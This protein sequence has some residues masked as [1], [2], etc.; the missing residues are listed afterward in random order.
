MSYYVF[1]DD[2]IFNPTEKRFKITDDNQKIL[3]HE[4]TEQDEGTYKCS[5]N[6]RKGSAEK[7]F[8]LKF[9]SE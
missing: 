1:Q 8:S 2:K 5:A 7:E 9:K 6:N 4:T 3:F